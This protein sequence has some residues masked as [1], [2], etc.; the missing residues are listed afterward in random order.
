MYPAPDPE[1]RDLGLTAPVSDDAVRSRLPGYLSGSPLLRYTPAAS[2]P[3]QVDLLVAPPLL[4]RSR[5][6]DG[7]RTGKTVGPP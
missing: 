5:D 2:V 4:D 1:T 7:G 6:D 3:D